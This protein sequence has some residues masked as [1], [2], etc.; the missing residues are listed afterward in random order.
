[1][2]LSH[3]T[4]REYNIIG[5]MSQDALYKS[6]IQVSQTQSIIHYFIYKITLL[7]RLHV[8]A[9]I[10]FGHHQVVNILMSRK[11]YNILHCNCTVSSLDSRICEWGLDARRR[12]PIHKYENLKRKLYNCNAIYCTV[13]LT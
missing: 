9:F 11:L 7:K 13:S 5:R 12:G 4:V 1:M 6:N 2:P 10:F 3:N 8:S